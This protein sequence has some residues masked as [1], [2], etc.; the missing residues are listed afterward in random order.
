MSD[1]CS[2]TRELDA[3][4]SVVAS[5]QRGETVDDVLARM[6]AKFGGRSA[7][8]VAAPTPPPAPPPPAPLVE[9][10]VDWEAP[11]LDAIRRH[12]GAANAITAEEL[13]AELHVPERTVRARV[14]HLR[15]AHDA[16]ICS[17]AASG[18]GRRA[19][20]YWPR[21]HEDVLECVRGL[22]SRASEILAAVDGL[23]RGAAA[24][25]GTLPL[26]GEN[27]W[28]AGAPGRR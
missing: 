12:T 24:E 23:R 2:E 27:G 16:P 4:D 5:R 20:F 25:F 26:F 6:N 7:P 18:A 3:I 28:G 9:P 14:T 15:V 21:R 1:V 17:S 10:C 11:L 19:G 13:G 22:S 8:E